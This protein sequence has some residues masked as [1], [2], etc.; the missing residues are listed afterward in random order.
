MPRHRGLLAPVTARLRWVF[1][2][3]KH[4]KNTQHTGEKQRRKIRDTADLIRSL[5]LN[6]QV[7]KLNLTVL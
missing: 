2:R 6:H 3:D 4:V 5:K 1:D 7:A